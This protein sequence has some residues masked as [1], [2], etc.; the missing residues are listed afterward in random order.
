MICLSKKFLQKG[1]FIPIEGK[2]P[3]C[4]EIFLWG[5]LIRKYKGCYENLDIT[6]DCDEIYDSE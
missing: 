3:K 4:G 5:D 1:E 6:L 2:C